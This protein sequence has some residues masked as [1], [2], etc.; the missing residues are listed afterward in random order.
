[1]DDAIVFVDLTQALRRTKVSDKGCID[2]CCDSLLPHNGE[3]YEIYH[4]LYRKWKFRAQ[5]YSENNPVPVTDRQG[6][7]VYLLPI[8]DADEIMCTWIPWAIIKIK[9]D[10]TAI[11]NQLP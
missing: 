9:E 2:K 10:Y 8:E 6:S 3:I 5:R 7:C 1:M 11:L 4:K